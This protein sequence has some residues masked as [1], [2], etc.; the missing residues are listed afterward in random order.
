MTSA[1]RLDGPG[2]YIE[3]QLHNGRAF[4]LNAPTT[5]P[6]ICGEGSDVVW[7]EGEP[8]LITGPQGVGK[9]TVQQQIALARGGITEP[10]VIGFPV[11]VTTGT[12]L[13][14]A[15]DR[16]R[17]IA[18]SMRR[19][20]DERHADLLEQRI[21]IWAGPLPFDLV[22][23]PHR[24]AEFVETLGADTVFIDSLKDIAWPLS[25]DEVGAA[26]NR[27]AGGVIAAGIQL[28][29]NHH[30]R[31]ATAENRKPTTL[32]DVYGSTWITSGAGSVISLWGEPGDP[33]VE[34]THL[35]QPAD[36]V[37]PLDLEHDHTTG[38]T[39]RRERADVWTALHSPGGTTA[40]D[41]ATLVYGKGYT[42]AQLEKVRRRLIRYVEDGHATPTKGT[43]TTD[44][45]VFQPTTKAGACTTV[46]PHVYPTRELHAATRNP[47]NTAH[48]SYTEP[49]HP[50]TPPLRG[51]RVGNRVRDHA[52]SE[53][54]L[55]ALVNRETGTR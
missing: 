31:K 20:V 32:A 47:E 45:I 15:A 44:P 34:L 24:L 52:R 41:A 1:L 55:Q 4:I 2:G 40:A 39:R 5:I 49:E 14:I 38:T 19:M 11:A 28:C 13:Y 17:Q 21:R 22:K 27:A 10:A 7:A 50:T 30:S 9:S 6:A 46:Y 37:G 51:G 53:D 33:L 43:H 25:S 36:D 18:R 16:P 54:E 8:L 12:V 3:R 29:A 35:K 42:R 26:W 23:E 48:A